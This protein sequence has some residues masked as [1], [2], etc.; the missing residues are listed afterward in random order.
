VYGGG[1]RCAIH[2]FFSAFTDTFEHAKFVTRILRVRM[3]DSQS[4]KIA[5]LYCD[6]RVLKYLVGVNPGELLTAVMK[7]SILLTSIGLC[8]FSFACGSAGNGATADDTSTGGPVWSDPVEVGAAGATSTDTLG[9][10][11]DVVE[12]TGEALTL[13]GSWSLQLPNDGT[14]SSVNSDHEPWYY[15]ASDG[16]R[17]FMDPDYGITTSGSKH[18]R[19]EL[20]ESKTWHGTGTNVMTVTGKVLQSS[21]ITVGQIFNSNDSITLAELQY[22]S[23]GFQVLYEEEKGHAL[24][25]VHVGGSVSVGK[26]YTFSMAYSKGEV[27]IKVNGGTYTHKPSSSVSGNN[28]YF[29]VGN[30]DQNA[31]KSTSV[32]KTVHS[33]V[34]NYSVSVSH[35]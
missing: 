21:T 31:T 27:T 28:F 7:H 18:P 22:T 6:I 25:S 9:S 8:L 29:K 3:S 12:S 1:A 24:P 10:E 11:A 30:Y 19:T 23:G 26:Q 15:K 14:E 4:T 20:R 2:G 17:V 13:S 35:S 34:E 5:S 33:R 32:S 16:G